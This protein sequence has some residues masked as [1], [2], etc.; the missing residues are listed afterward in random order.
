MCQYWREIRTGMSGEC[1]HALSQRSD[2]VDSH[3]D[4]VY[5]TNL[6]VALFFAWI[7]NL[8]YGSDCYNKAFYFACNAAYPT[9]SIFD[10]CK[11]S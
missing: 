2:P 3:L 9:C 6:A 5:S 10:Q 8:T 1:R 11:D 7:V 4:Y